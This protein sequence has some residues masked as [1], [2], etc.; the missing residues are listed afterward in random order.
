MTSGSGKLESMTGLGWG[1]P[2]L[3]GRCAGELTAGLAAGPL[4]PPGRRPVPVPGSST[5]AAAS[6]LT[7]ATSTLTSAP[8]TT[9]T[10][11]GYLTA[12]PPRESSGPRVG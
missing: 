1:R 4:D 12:P 2:A 11:G 5:P 8:T 3:I 9:A 10:S 6:A 7:T